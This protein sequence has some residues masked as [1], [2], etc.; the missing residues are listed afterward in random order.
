MRSMF[1]G[2]SSAM[3]IRYGTKPPHL[4]YNALQTVNIA[5]T[6]NILLAFDLLKN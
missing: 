5:Q 3:I 1:S 4:I 6:A 2:L